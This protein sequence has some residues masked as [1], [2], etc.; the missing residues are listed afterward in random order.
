LIELLELFLDTA[1]IVEIRNA[2]RLGVITGITTN[3]KI[4]LAERGCNFKERVQEI[5]SLVDGPL[6]VELTKTEGTDE[7]MIAEA[8]EYSSWNPKN[9]TIKV[10]MFGNGRGL[11]IISQLGKR[12]V[13]TNATALVSVNQVMLAAKAGATYASIFFNRVKDAGEDAERAVSQSRA[14]LDRMDT[15]TKIIVGSIRKAADVVQ[16]AIAGAHVITIPY[17]ILTEMPFHQ[18][19]EETIAEFDRAWQEFK[20]AEKESL[21]GTRS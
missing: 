17:K 11:G 5:L 9:V 18:K 3:Q 2:L 8:V 1:S 19:T 13:K 16:A 14:L 4:F 15:P 20:L 21:S 10:P 7:E 6:S 12:N